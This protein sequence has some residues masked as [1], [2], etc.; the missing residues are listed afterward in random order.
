MGRALQHVALNCRDRKA[1]ER[2]YA[3]HF[4]FTRARVFEGGRP[5]EFVMLKLGDLRF[6]LF[7]SRGVPPGARGGEQP[8]G[9]KH[10]CLEVPDV[11]AKAGELR[12]EGLEPGPVIDC[13]HQVPGLRICFLQDPEGNT[14]ELLEGW[15]DDPDP[16]ALE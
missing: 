6:E 7:Q 1:Q 9:F 5:D 13:S 10:L 12:A 14:I 16:P 4:G 15:K 8:V 11:A 3:R 2:F